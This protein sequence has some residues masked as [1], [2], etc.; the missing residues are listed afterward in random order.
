MRNPHHSNHCSLP[1]SVLTCSSY[2][3]NFLYLIY[4]S[5]YLFCLGF[6]EILEFLNVCLSPNLGMFFFKYFFYLILSLSFF[7]WTLIT[8][9]LDLLVLFHRSVR[10]YSFFSPIFFYLSFLRIRYFL[11]IYLKVQSFL[12]QLQSVKPIQ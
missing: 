5:K 2:F 7:S 9:M 4:K 6:S 11:L 1:C 3:Q 8:G 10:L 12:C